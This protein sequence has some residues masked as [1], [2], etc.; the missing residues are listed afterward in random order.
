MVENKTYNTLPDLLRAHESVLATPVP[1]SVKFDLPADSIYGGGAALDAMLE[2]ARVPTIKAAEVYYH[3]KIVLNRHWLQVTLELREADLMINTD[4]SPLRKTIALSDVTE[5]TTCQPP[6]SAQ[7]PC[8][9]VAVGNQAYVFGCSD[10]DQWVATVSAAAAEQRRHRAAQQAHERSDEEKLLTRVVS[11]QADSAEAVQ[12]MKRLM[13]SADRVPGQLG[14]FDHSVL[15]CLNEYLAK[16]LRRRTPKAPVPQ[17]QFSKLDLDLNLNGAKCEVE[18]PV[19]DALT[20]RN[21][22][23]A[24]VKISFASFK[25]AMAT[26]KFVPDRLTIAAGATEEVHV[27]LMMHTTATLNELVH[28]AVQAERGKAVASIFVALRVTSKMMEALDFSSID[29]GPRLGAGAFG[30][31]FHGTCQVSCRRLNTH[32]RSSSHACTGTRSGNQSRRL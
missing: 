15:R 18:V 22:G 27:T 9:R 8:F 14:A 4:K 12:D 19:R 2:A 13:F 20:V 16:Q 29:F 24:A 31:V 26:L 21:T 30:Q 6:S 25:R 3:A 10:P 11:R 32:C 5:C 23:Q 17:L 28:V 7:M 1:N